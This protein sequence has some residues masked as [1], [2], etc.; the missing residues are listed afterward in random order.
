MKNHCIAGT[1]GVIAV[2][3]MAFGMAAAA[4][5]GDAKRSDANTQ[6]LQEAAQG[7]MAE[8]ALGQM[9]VTKAQH[10]AVK[11]FGQR[12]VTDHSKANMEL[13]AL[14]QSEGVTL[15]QEVDAK[16]QAL[17]VRLSQLSSAEFD[18]AYMEEMVKD[19]RDTVEKF[20]QAVDQEQDPQIKQW[21]AAT[22][23]T[24]KEHLQEANKT[25]D[26]VGVKVSDTEK[27]AEKMNTAE[28]ATKK[29]AAEKASA[30]RGDAEDTSI[31]NE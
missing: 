5:H 10:D 1:A 19:H 18:R 16:A 27:T 6:F 22:L 8:V 11:Q 15:P 3:C 2:V 17:Q 23:P 24:L 28:A 14:A 9:A 29:M 25:A 26:L 12:M 20:Q 30:K 13:K 4:E 31:D 21:A 7:G